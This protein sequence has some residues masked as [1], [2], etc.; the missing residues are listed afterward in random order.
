MLPAESPA[1]PGWVSCFLNWW[2][3]V[4]L[5]E[6]LSL[7]SQQNEAC[8]ALL[9]RVALCI[10]RFW[11]C[12]SLQA[13]DTNLKVK[14][15]GKHH[16]NLC[17]GKKTVGDSSRS[18]AFTGWKNIYVGSWPVGWNCKVLT[19]WK[20]TWRQRVKD[21]QGISGNNKGWEESELQSC[22][23]AV[24]CL[25]TELTALCLMSAG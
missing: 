6:W 15:C 3:A 7:I 25:L 5:C 14:F 1:R 10:P 2:G 11:Q 13:G 24:I 4:K 20:L 21:F 12:F 8:A 18:S 9:L 19:S 23:C 16:G 22:S 17:P